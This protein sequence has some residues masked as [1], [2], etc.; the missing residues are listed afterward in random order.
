MSNHPIATLYCFSMIFH[1]TVQFARSPPRPKAPGQPSKQSIASQLTAGPGE[2]HD[3]ATRAVPSA[4]GATAVPSGAGQLPQA[5]TLLKNTANRRQPAC[6]AKPRCPRTG[7]RFS[8]ATPHSDIPE[9]A[10]LRNDHTRT[11][12]ACQIFACDGR[13]SSRPTSRIIACS[14]QHPGRGGR[15]AASFAAKPNGSRQS[16]R[17]PAWGADRPRRGSG[18]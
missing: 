14:G 7:R 13:A 12:K 6:S 1:F 3:A 10:T 2:V 4:S 11:K 16:R 5:R 18:E 15:P 17:T 9:A 8:R